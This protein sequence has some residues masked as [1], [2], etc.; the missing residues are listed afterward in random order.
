M[1]GEQ[2]PLHLA[3]ELDAVDCIKVLLSHGA[4]LNAQDGQMLTPLLAA[5]AGNCQHASKALMEAGASLTIAD[6]EENAPLH[7][8]SHH[9]AVELAKLAL[10]K[11]AQIDALNALSETALLTATKLGKRKVVELLLKEGATVQRDSVGSVAPTN[12]TACHF[13][14]QY[15]AEGGDAADSCAILSAI[16]EK[17]PDVNAVDGEKRS[18]LHYV[19]PA[20]R[21]CTLR[22]PPRV[23]LTPPQPHDLQ[24]RAGVPRVSGPSTARGVAVL[25]SHRPSGP[26]LALSRLW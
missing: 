1:Q 7:W 14:M 25:L 13:A 23:R 17:K 18:A 22:L 2:T 24:P 5:C 11:G 10:Q 15:G 21:P 6:E 3:A 4:N 8:L 26:C 9:D 20:A 12:K 16:L 19:S